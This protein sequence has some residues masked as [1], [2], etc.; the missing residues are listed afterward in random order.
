MRKNK[1]T[2]IV[3]SDIFLIPIFFM[4]FWP[5]ETLPKSTRVCSLDKIIISGFTDGHTTFK[6]NVLQ[7]LKEENSCVSVFIN[8]SE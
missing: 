8:K 6:Y 1:V 3:D 2:S 5:I 4:H 7:T